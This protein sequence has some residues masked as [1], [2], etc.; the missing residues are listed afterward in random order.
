M[1]GKRKV[2]L[3]YTKDQLNFP[4]FHIWYNYK[5]ASQNLLDSWEEKRVTGFR[6]SWRIENPTLAWTTSISEVGRSIQSPLH[7][8]EST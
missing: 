4:G 7:G 5:A 1:I 8:E 3:T 2:N 6:L